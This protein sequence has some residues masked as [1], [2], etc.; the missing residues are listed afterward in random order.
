MAMAD[1]WRDVEE[2]S[3]PK[4]R[5]FSGN[6]GGATDAATIDVWAARHLQRMLN[7]QRLPPPIEGGVKGKM[8]NTPPDNV[9][10]EMGPM[11]A[12]LRAG[13]EFG[14]GQDVFENLANRINKTGLL[15]PYLEQL[16]YTNA[17]PMD[18][19]ALAWFLE[20][21]H[22]T[23][24]NWTTA[25]G[26]GGSFE[27]EMAKY[28][29]QR[30][31]S[32][33]SIQQNEPP[34]DALMAKTKDIVDS[35]LSNDPNVS[36]YRTHPTVG[37]YAGSNERSFDSELTAHPDWNPSQWMAS[38]IQQAKEHNQKDLFFSKRLS[39]EQAETNPNAR[40][41]AEIYFQNRKDMESILPILDE[42]TNR[43][44]DG[45]TFVTDLRHRERIG[46]GAEQPDYVGVRM[47]YVPE[48]AMRYDPEFRKKALEDPNFL[49][50]SMQ[51]AQDRMQDAIKAIDQ[52]GHKIVDARI[53]HYDTLALGHE[54]YDKFLN[55]ITEP[56]NA[57]SAYEE[58][59][60]AVNPIA[61]FG[62]HINTHVEGRDRA[63]R[64][65]V[66]GGEPNLGSTVA[67][68]NTG[69]KQYA[70]GGSVKLHNKNKG[71]DLTD[72]ALFAVRKFGPAAAQDAVHIAK[73]L[74]RGRP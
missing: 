58:K 40:P 31:Q 18:L 16:G 4:A 7:R 61:R 35:T 59:S 20:K 56:H 51:E 13:G 22:W 17:T 54:S 15:N 24:N 66:K 57:S 11:P 12:T 27:Q 21:E 69:V 2:G 33:F 67:Q 30:W 5:N 50:N 29:S 14:F 28:P 46:G 52:R 60:R 8:M 9:V 23:K 10:G 37:R 49:A 34:T 65:G 43:G 72:R 63:L 38:I 55:G 64:E 32:G 70:S 19:Q 47:Q 44:Q 53:H 3:A 42:F 62:Q 48:I 74:T 39:P 6:L 68:P 45:F 73:Q 1:R 26:E 36:V 41:G 25:A 71:R